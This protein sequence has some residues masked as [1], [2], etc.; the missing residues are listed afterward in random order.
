M[1]KISNKIKGVFRV[2]TANLFGLGVSM[3]TSLVLPLAISVGEYGRWQLFSLYAQY[4]GFFVLGFNDGIHL[5]YAD[6]DYTTENQAKFKTFFRHL[7]IVGIVE[8][9]LLIA[10]SFLLLK[11][12]ATRYMAL[13]VSLN[14]LPVSLSGLFLY[15]NQGMLRFKQY[16]ILTVLDKTVF[17][18]LLII[19][20]C[21]RTQ[22]A[23]YYIIAYTVTRYITLTYLYFS[24]KEVFKAKAQPL[25]EVK[26]EI[27]NNYKKGFP[28][29]IAAI[30]GGPTLIVGG[31]LLVE[32][33]FGIESFSAYSFSLNTIIVAAQF[34]AAISAVF[35]PILKRTT[36]EELPIMYRSFDKITTL[37]S[38]VLLLS[39]YPAALLVN[40][41]YVKYNSILSYLFMVYPLFIYQCKSNVLIKNAYKVKNEPTKLIFVNLIG[42][43]I[44]LVCIFVAYITF[45]SVS[46]IAAATLLS[47]GIWYYVMQF[48]ITRRE[49]WA[50][51]SWMLG[52]AILVALFIVYNYLLTLM[53]SDTNMRMV[54]GFLA[55]AGLCVVIYFV[56]KDKV[57]SIIR[58]FLNLMKD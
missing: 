29:M 16:S 36:K 17:M 19:L 55:M 25:N 57:R 13:I 42:I 34:I 44:H 10:G 41:L 12:P 39:Y 7:G 2:S 49:G 48:H 54:I 31:R 58:E 32:H 43:I 9:L 33:K 18:I 22:E 20:L 45:H 1:M 52:D 35:Y 53:I 28:L 11:D 27:I 5:N 15:M 24:S 37:F 56:F 21:L 3:L 38:F 40:L 8:T 14:L 23:F 46:S 51:R 47:L 50:F 6:C 26:P 4:L 30:F